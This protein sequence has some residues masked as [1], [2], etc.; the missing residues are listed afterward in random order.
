MNIKLIKATNDDMDYVSSFKLKSINNVDIIYANNIKVGI[1]EY[2]EKDGYINLELIEIEKEY[3]RQGIA[4]S[5]IDLIKNEK[6]DILGD[7][8]PNEVSIAFWTELGS[9]FE[10]SVEEGLAYNCCIPFVLYA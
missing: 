1:L 10:E 2:R 3:R 4:K 6:G 8:A 5:V 7:C 9:E